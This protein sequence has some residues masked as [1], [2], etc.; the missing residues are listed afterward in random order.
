[1]EVGQPFVARCGSQRLGLSNPV[2]A[3]PRRGRCELSV[4][5]SGKERLGRIVL[6][7]VG[8]IKGDSDWGCRREI[9]IKIRI[10]VRRDHPKK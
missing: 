10:S 9:R 2:L 4:A 7:R 1:M 8:L 3:P 6:G 5:G